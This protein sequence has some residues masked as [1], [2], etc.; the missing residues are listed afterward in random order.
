MAPGGWYPQTMSKHLSLKYLQ[1]K[2][3]YRHSLSNQ[4]NQFLEPIYW[5]VSGGVAPKTFEKQNCVCSLTTL[6]KHYISMC[7][8]LEKSAH[9]IYQEK[10]KRTHRG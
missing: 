5:G 7:Y 1:I 2:K 6:C 9:K 4:K 10:Q 3:N 8:G